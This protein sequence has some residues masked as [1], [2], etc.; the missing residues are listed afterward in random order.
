MDV[1]PGDITGMISQLRTIAAT[2]LKTGVVKPTLVFSDPETKEVDYFVAEQFV[3]E[4]QKAEFAEAAA[5]H[6]VSLQAIP[7]VMGMVAN[8]WI[9]SSEYTGIGI[10]ITARNMID[11]NM[12]MYQ[13]YNVDTSGESPVLAHSTGLQQGDQPSDVIDIM[14]DTITHI[15]KLTNTDK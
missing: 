1:K 5:K 4:K 11:N 15:F 7:A 10:L 3:D 14:G 13:F 8:G 12:T 6:I 9:E 2:Q